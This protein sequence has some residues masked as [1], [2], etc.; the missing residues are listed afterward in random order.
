MVKCLI[1]WSKIKAFPAAKGSRIDV[2]R[3]HLARELAE[4]KVPHKMICEKL[5]NMSRSALAY[6]IGDEHPQRKLTPEVRKKRQARKAKKTSQN[7]LF[8]RLMKKDT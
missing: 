3:R 6:I 8:K 4:L 2:F 5:G 7:Q 1:D